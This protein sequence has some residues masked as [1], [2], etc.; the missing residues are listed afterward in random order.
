MKYIMIISLIA[1]A[2]L[3]GCTNPKDTIET[4]EAMGMTN[5]QV[6][7]Y[8]MFACGTDDQTSTKFT[9]T[10][11]QGKQVTG[12]SCGMFFGKD[13]TIRGLKVVK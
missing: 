1:M 10:N 8:S 2:A 13:S 5:V 4:A 7:G 11:A 3:S 6:G 9:A 12:T